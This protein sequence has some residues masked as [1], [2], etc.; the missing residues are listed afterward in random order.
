MGRLP[1]CVVGG[2]VRIVFRPVNQ[3]P[4][5]GRN[6]AARRQTV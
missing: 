3:Y 6:I 4:E 2:I 5:C 1:G